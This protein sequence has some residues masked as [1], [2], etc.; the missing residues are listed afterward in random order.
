M[1]YEVDKDALTLLRAMK[2]HH[3]RHNPHTPLPEG[4]RL[5]PELVAKEVRLE[6]K[7]CDTRGC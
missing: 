3:D 1:F 7:P 4:T 5:A 6:P 2:E